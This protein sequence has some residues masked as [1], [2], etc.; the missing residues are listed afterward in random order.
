[1]CTTIQRM[2]AAI[3]YAVGRI[4]EDVSMDTDVNISKDVMAAITEMTT[5]QCT[6]FATDLELFAK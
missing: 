1:M 2:K 4:C 3:H 5:Q 6:T